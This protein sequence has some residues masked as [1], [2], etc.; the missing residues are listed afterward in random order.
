MRRPPAVRRGT[1]CCCPTRRWPRSGCSCPRWPSGWSPRSSTRCPATRT[2]SAARWAKPSA[3]PCSSRW[4]DSSPWPAVAAAPIRARRP[5]RRWRAP[6]SSAAARP[7]AAGPPTRCCRRTGSAPGS[8]GTRCRRPPYRTGWTPRRWCRSRSWCSPTSTSCRPPASPGTPT[9]WPPP[10]GSG[11]GC[12]SGSPTTCSPAPRPR[13]SSRP[14]SGPSGSR[15]RTLTAV[16]VPEAQVRP[17][18]S[19]LSSRTLQAG[20]VPGARRRGAAAGP[21]RARPAAR[22]GPPGDRGPRRHRRPAAALAR[23][24][25]RRTRGRCGRASWGSGRT[26]RPASPSWC[27]PPTRRRWPTSAT[28]ALA[29]MKSVAAGHRREARRDPPRLAAPPRPPGG[30]RDP[31]VRAPADRALPDGSAPR[32]V[33][34]AARRPRLRPAA[35]RRPGLEPRRRRDRRGIGTAVVGPAQR[36]APHEPR[37]L[38]RRTPGS[39]RRRGTP[40]GTRRSRCAPRHRRGRRT[41]GRRAGAAAACRAGGAGVAARRRRTPRSCRRS[42]RRRAG[43]RTRRRGRDAAPPTAPRSAGSRRRGPGTAGQ[44]GRRAAVRSH[45]HRPDAHGPGVVVV[46]L[47]EQVVHAAA[48]AEVRRV[49]QRRAR[50]RCSAAG[51]ASA[52]TDPSASRRRPSRCSRTHRA[53]RR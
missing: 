33:R 9:S 2:R 39:C 51:G 47:V 10:D 43:R 14:R 21:R 53:A 29:P 40:S 15:R 23:G 4:A 17:V 8:P 24:A 27:S 28:Q 31:A 7:A 16:I 26:P 44:P 13:P 3:T 11:S 18:L 19:A 12:R 41:A 25:P 1:D 48:G 45:P 6:T 34:R 5:P 49:D 42:C 46:P 36:P 35:H 32:A 20:D 37:R 38:R 22:H 52:R 30:G 50:G